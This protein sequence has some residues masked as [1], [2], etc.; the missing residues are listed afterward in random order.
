MAIRAPEGAK[1]KSNNG[2]RKDNRVNN[3]KGKKRRKTKKTMRKKG[4]SKGRRMRL[5]AGRKTT[6]LRRVLFPNFIQFDI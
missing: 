2:R 4:N 1:K 3:K 6:F 5:D